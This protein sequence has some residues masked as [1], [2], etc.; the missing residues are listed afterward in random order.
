M[1]SPSGTGLQGIASIVFGAVQGILRG[2]VH[3]DDFQGAMGMPGWHGQKVRH[4]AWL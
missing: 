2:N 4:R 1:T 3:F